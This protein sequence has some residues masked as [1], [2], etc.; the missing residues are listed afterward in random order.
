MYICSFFIL[1]LLLHT[2]FFLKRY[3]IKGNTRFDNVTCL[4]GGGGGEKLS[5]S[6]TVI[7]KPYLFSY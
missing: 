1:F 3:R 6:P 4:V 5:G 2:C 7:P